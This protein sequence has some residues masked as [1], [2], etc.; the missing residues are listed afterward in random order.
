[1]AKIE[2]VPLLYFMLSLFVLLLANGKGEPKTE[3]IKGLFMK[4]VTIRLS[5]RDSP[6]SPLYRANLTS[7]QTTQRLVHQSKARVRLL[8]DTATN[9]STTKM[10]C[11]YERS[12]RQCRLA[13]RFELHGESRD[14]KVLRLLQAVLRVLSTRR[15]R[16]PDDMGPMPGSPHSIPSQLPPLLPSNRTHLPFKHLCLI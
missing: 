7:S 13:I 9:S 16:Q 12:P 15:H 4:G 3:L 5:H 2:A 6:D 10:N 8:S 1:M 11:I 14:R